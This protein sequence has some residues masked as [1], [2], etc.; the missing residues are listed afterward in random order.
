MFSFYRHSAPER[1]AVPRAELSR[2]QLGAVIAGIGAA[3][4]IAG[5]SLLQIAAVREVA[6]QVAPRVF[7]IVNADEVEKPTLP[8]PVPKPTPRSR[9]VVPVISTPSP[10]HGAFVTEPA[11]P[12]S[13]APELSIESVNTQTLSASP[14]APPPAKVIPASAIQYRIPPPLEYPRASKP[15]RETGRVIARVYV[16]EGGVPQVIQVKKSS[17]FARLDEAALL[18]VQKARFKPYTEN[19]QPTAGWALIPLDFELE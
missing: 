17:G 9:P 1:P 5:W 19:G 18:A 2:K 6:A 10:N 14:P 13:H 8:P 12:E 15:F 11:E 16:D 4:I 7:S 3:H